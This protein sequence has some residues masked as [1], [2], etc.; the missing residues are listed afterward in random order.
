LAARAELAA[1]AVRSA[2]ERV[3]A[4]TVGL[5]EAAEADRAA[6]RAASLLHDDIEHLRERTTLERLREQRERLRLARQGQAAAEAVL[7][8]SKVTDEAL[9][10]I[11][12]ASVEVQTARARLEA[13]SPAVI[14]ESLGAARVE[15]DGQE[16]DLGPGAAAERSVIGRLRV[17]VPAAVRVTV[18]A[19]SDGAELGRALAAAQDAYTRACGIAGVDDLAEAETAAVARRDA[20]SAR[21]GH[22][23]A[24]TSLLEGLGLPSADEL[25]TRIAVAE[26][27]STTYAHQRPAEPALPHDPE[28]ARAALGAAEQ[29]RQEA[30]TAEERARA[31]DEAAR[32]QLKKVE[33]AATEVDVRLQLAEQALAASEASLAQARGVSSDEDLAA[34][35]AEAET[36]EHV[37]ENAVEAARAA[38]EAEGPEALR[39]RLDNAEAVLDGA[40]QRLRGVEDHLLEVQTRLRDHQEDG[41]SERRDQAIAALDVATRELSAYRRRAAARKLL[42]GTL[43]EA[44]EEAHR[45][46]IGPLRE[47]IEELG[48]VVYGESFRV[49]LSEDLR[50]ASRTLDGQTVPFESLSIGT[51]E[52]LGV[53]ARLACAIIVARD[54][55]A[56]LILDDT[57]GFSDP[58]RLEAMGAVLGL[59]GNACQVIALTCHPDRYRHVGGATIR[60]LG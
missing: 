4:A 29:A 1:P 6:E 15:V 22:R 53:I 60:R 31:E 49:E 43:E 9:D 11:R 25:D 2:R 36:A 48:R 30:R 59:A 44:R 41:L 58:S 45:A 10:A 35:R 32:E 50:I 33:S 13:G 42:F 40:N 37:A 12:T 27:R 46:Y 20:E 19:G 18:S 55:G 28:S 23:R 57:L 5:A 3:E 7:T 47:R 39:T 24:I 21:E 56:P 38:L 14:I 8:T 34:L 16:L 17:E 54:E 52:Q 26:Q 51:K